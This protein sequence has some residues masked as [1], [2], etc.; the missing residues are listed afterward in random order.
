MHYFIYK[1]INNINNKIYIGIHK[2]KNLN[3]GYLGSGKL[4]LQAIKKYGKENFSREILQYFDSE[5]EMSLQE[6]VIVDFNFVSRED[7]YN[8]MVGGKYG[9]KERNGLTFLGN[10]HSTEVKAIL[11]EYGLCKTHSVESKLKMSQNNFSKRDPE[12]Q[13]EHAKRAGSYKKTDEHKLK[14]S[15]SLKKNQTNRN[16]DLGKT[17]LGK[18]REKVECPYCKKQ[19]AMNTMSRWHFDNC[20]FVQK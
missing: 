4:L 1:T 10:N 2:T 18:I 20:K 5:Y 19:G 7:T 11:R 17:N 13:R 12:K 6:E 3:D 16:P 9:S 8:I 15:E 14:I